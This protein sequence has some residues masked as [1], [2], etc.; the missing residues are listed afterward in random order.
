VRSNSAAIAKLMLE[1]V[2]AAFHKHIDPAS[3]A[4]WGGDFNAP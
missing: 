3:W 4:A 2:N 1:P